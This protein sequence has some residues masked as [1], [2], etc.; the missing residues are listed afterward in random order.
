MY[1]HKFCTSL[2]Q[3]WLGTVD[4]LTA[5]QLSSI[6]AKLAAEEFDGSEL[7]ELS[8]PKT[9]RRLL[10]GTGAEE[11]VPLLLAARDA[12]LGEAT[13]CTQPPS[14]PPVLLSSATLP[15]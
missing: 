2:L 3:R 13:C 4:G 1:V 14:P 9:F 8:S 6:Q 11:A 5:E 12:Y 10:R 7:V 15:S